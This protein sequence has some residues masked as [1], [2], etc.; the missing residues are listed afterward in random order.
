MP[1]TA[2]TSY[3]KEA[4]GYHNKTGANKTGA[5]KGGACP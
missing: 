2:A 5:N 3:F 1:Y 4:R